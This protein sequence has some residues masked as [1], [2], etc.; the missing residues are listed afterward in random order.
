MEK[1][2]PSFPLPCDFK[3]CPAPLIENIANYFYDLSNYLREFN[4]SLH[5]THQ[6]LAVASSKFAHDE[7]SSFLFARSLTQSEHSLSDTVQNLTPLYDSLRDIANSFRALLSP[8][9]V[10]PSVPVSESASDTPADTPSNRKLSHTTP[11]PPLPWNSLTS[12]Y[13]TSNLAP[14]L[15]PTSATTS[16][17]SIPIS[18]KPLKT[19][20]SRCRLDT[21]L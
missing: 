8:E 11:P 15:L 5:K 9:E 6:S 14:T 3:A 2:I 4:T 21:T 16:T 17:P 1:S 18:P 13:P 10:D 19:T 7:I 12:P 20:S